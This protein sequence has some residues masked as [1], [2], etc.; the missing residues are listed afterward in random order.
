MKKYCFFL[1]CMLLLDYKLLHQG[2]QDEVFL[3]G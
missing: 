1:F 3:A 2:G